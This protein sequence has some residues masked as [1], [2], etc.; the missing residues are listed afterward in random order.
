MIVQRGER[1]MENIQATRE[2]AQF[3]KYFSVHYKLLLSR[4]MK[5][6][7][8]EKI[9][10]DD[11][12][13]GTYFDIIIVQLRA[14]CIES[15]H[16]ENNYTIQTALRRMG[17]AEYADRIDR[18]LEQQF[19]PCADTFTTRKALKMLADKFICH[20]DN[21]DGA[22][23]EGWGFGVVIEKRLMNPYDNPNLDTIMS[24]I[25]EC[26]YEGFDIP[27]IMKDHI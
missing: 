9:N 25:V 13:L 27:K 23:N 17:K 20:Y 26:I 24:E 16:L 7:S 8:L 14:L 19:L 5:Y 3:I 11:I 4:Y 1:L 6:K 2:N 21:F 22:N 10:N 15:P 12:D 18:M